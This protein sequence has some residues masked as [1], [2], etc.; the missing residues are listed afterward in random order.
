MG[1]IPYAYGNN[2]IYIWEKYHIH[3]GIIPYTH[4]SNTVCI[5]EQYHIHMGKIPYT[6]CWNNTIYIWEQYH[7]HMGTIP[8]A[9]GNSTICIWEQYH[10]HMGTVPYMRRGSTRDEVFP[11]SYRQNRTSH[12]ITYI[13]EGVDSTLLQKVQSQGVPHR[14]CF[15]SCCARESLMASTSISTVRGSPS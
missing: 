10:I 13:E 6:Y 12:C 8:F 14:L 1:A 2:T 4:G 9:Y 11:Y 5:W 15:H 3:I 7:I